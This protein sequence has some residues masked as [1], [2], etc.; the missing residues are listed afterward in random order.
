MIDGQS[1]VENN[2][3]Y[4]VLSLCSYHILYLVMCQALLQVLHVTPAS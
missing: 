3:S 1:E 2:S 4:H